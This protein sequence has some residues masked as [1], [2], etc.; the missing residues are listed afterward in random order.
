MAT[1]LLD[2][3]KV[4]MET[5]EAFFPSENPVPKGWENGKAEEGQK[6]EDE[7]EIRRKLFFRK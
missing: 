3:T 4:N 6:S 5:L 2:L 7:F 1:P